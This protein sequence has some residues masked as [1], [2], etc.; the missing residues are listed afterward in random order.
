MEF[1]CVAVFAVLSL[2]QGE[3]GFGNKY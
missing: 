1:L 3:E 2:A